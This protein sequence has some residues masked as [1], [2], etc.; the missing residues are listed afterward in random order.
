MQYG[1]SRVPSGVHLGL[2]GRHLGERAPEM[3]GPGPPA[4]LGAP[5]DR[6]GERPVDLAHARPVAKA[7]ELPAVAVGKGVAGHVDERR[8]A[9]C[10][11]P[12][13][14][15]GGAPTASRPTARSRS[16]HR[17]SPARRS[18]PSVMVELPPATTGQP[19]AWAVR[20]SRVPKALV[21]GAVSDIEWAPTPASSALASSDSNRRTS[22]CMGIRPGRPNR[23]RATGWL[24]NR[25][26]RSQH[27]VG[28]GLAVPHQRLHQ[29]PVGGPV[30][31]E[32]RPPSPRG[33]GTQ[34]PRWSRRWAGRTAPSGWQRASRRPS[35]AGW[36]KNGDTST[37]GWTAEHTSWRKP[38]TVR[39]SVRH[40][41]PGSL[42]TFDHRHRQTGAGQGHRGGQPVRSRPHHHH[43]HGVLGVTIGPGATAE[44][45][46]DVLPPDVM[47]THIRSARMATGSGRTDPDGHG[48]HRSGLGRRQARKRN[49]RSGVV[50]DEQKRPTWRV[51]RRKYGAADGYCER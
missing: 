18:A 26:E 46:R 49:G 19:T 6:A 25:A 1:R 41:P 9:T 16:S 17:A 45:H 20:A 31:P 36:R 4:D 39:S 3:H 21:S 47:G 2:A 23:A 27:L 44:A 7:P 22:H 40:P 12:P 24:G 38:G 48:I 11:G 5:G 13:P 32:R 37:I 50:P 28:D 10:R 30:G 8:W 35:K 34:P 43:V 14:S 29:P 42:G 15:R 33:T 51:R